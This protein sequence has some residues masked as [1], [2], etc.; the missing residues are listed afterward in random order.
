[1][2]RLRSLLLPV[3]SLAI[4]FVGNSSS[5]AQTTPAPWSFAGH[6]AYNTRSTWTAADADQ[7]STANVS[8]LAVKWQF[9]SHGSIAVTPTV[10][11]GGLYVTDAAGYLYKVDPDSGALLWEVNLQSVTG[12]STSYSLTS[13]AISNNTVVVGDRAG[14]RLMAFNKTTGAHLWSTLVDPHPYGLITGAVTV[15]S[16]VV[17]AGVSSREESFAINSTYVPTFRGSV[18]ALNLDTGAIIW[19]FKTVPSGYAGGAVWGGNIVVA[20]ALG[21]EGLVFAGTGNNYGL[22][23]AVTSCLNEPGVAGNVTAQYAC[24]SPADYVD[25]ILALNMKTG[26]L[27]WSRRFEGADT[28]TVGCLL[29]GEPGCPVP[30]GKDADFASAPNLLNSPSLVGMPDDRGGVSNGWLLG[31]G[32][33]SG[34][35]WGLNPANGGLFWATQVG[36]GEILWGSS[37]VGVGSNNYVFCAI[38]NQTQSNHLIGQGGSHPLTWGAGFWSGINAMTG[39]LL[40]QV[41]AG[42]ADL[43]TPTLG[44]SAQGPMS[45]INYVVFAGDTGGNL[46]ALSAHS[47]F[48]FWTFPT[49]VT[50]TTAPALFNNTVYW[51][52]GG[53]SSTSVPGNTLYAFA[54]PAD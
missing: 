43:E 37:V 21:T 35:Y 1:V 28:W 11:Q 4:S 47:G 22:P 54:V 19:Q 31:A 39:S 50:V 29:T 3:A 36:K 14:A 2:G 9:K 46:V 49:G 24:L 13:P 18:V 12:V 32:E 48:K 23:A 5:F 6:D 25:A 7:L 8:K 16:G 40:W 33:K 53:A 51:G 30:T 41:P 15:S 17:Y 42:P 20:P 27:V 38:N 44:A 10:E 52:V 26:A 45:F 34:I